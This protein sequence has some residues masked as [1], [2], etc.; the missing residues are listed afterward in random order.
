MARARK[1]KSRI[2][3]FNNIL[4]G[5]LLSAGIGIMAYPSISDMIV[6]Y[7]LKQEMAQ[8]NTALEGY[9]ENYDDMWAPAE[10]YN[11]WLVTKD[12]PL[13]VTPEENEYVRT[14]LNPLGTGMIGSIEIPKIG[15]NIPFFYGT[16]EQQLQSGAGYWMGSSLP[17]GGESTHTVLTAHT[18]LVRAKLFTDID[19]LEN[20]DTFTIRVLDRILTYEVDNRQIVDPDVVE[21]MYIVPGE[22][23]VTLYTCY[24]Y[25]V[26]SHRLLVRAHRIPNEESVPSQ[27]EQIR[28]WL[29]EWWP[30]MVG[31]LIASLLLFW[32]WK[33]RRSRRKTEAPEAPAVL[34]I[35]VDVL[36]GVKKEPG[37]IRRIPVRLRTRLLPARVMKQSDWIQEAADQAEQRKAA[38]P[39]RRRRQ[40]SSHPAKTQKKEK[41]RPYIAD[42]VKQSGLATARK[43][44]LKKKNPAERGE[45]HAQTH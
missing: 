8:Y 2:S 26:N 24:P 43:Q 34:P 3:Q 31:G 17:T 1:K 20:G 16:D 12:Q 32:N 19:K 35:A 30:W 22:D 15:V 33:K 6:N 38:L 9:E 14:L 28:K 40:T 23:L 25:G 4:I 45:E 5:L 18:G 41:S 36:G 10:E 37:W 39:P 29:E 21:P 13:T 27:E 42:R 44:A 11:R 7:Q